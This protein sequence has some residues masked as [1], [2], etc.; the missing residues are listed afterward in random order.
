MKKIRLSEESLNK[1]EKRL[2]NEISYGTVERA[3]DKGDMIFTHLYSAFEDFLSAL[4]ESILDS[5]Q[6][7]NGYK[8]NA[9]PYLLKIKEMSEPIQDILLRKRDQIDNFNQEL[10]KFDELSWHDDMEDKGWPQDDYSD[11]DLRDLQTKYPPT[12]HI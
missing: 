6:G 7:A 2:V 3:S 5:E 10:N 9:N 4:N 11:E 1:L 12:K 8:Q